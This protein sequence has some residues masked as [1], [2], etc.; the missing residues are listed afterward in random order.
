MLFEVLGQLRRMT[1]GFCINRSRLI[2]TAGI[3]GL[4]KLG[5][6]EG[7]ASGRQFEFAHGPRS[8]V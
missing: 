7:E 2:G 6:D 8:S 3:E 1:H 5:E 4:P